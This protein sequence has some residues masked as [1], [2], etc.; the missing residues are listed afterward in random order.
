M[1][2]IVVHNAMGDK[3][4]AGLSTEISSLID[5]DIFGVSVM[6]PDP[7]IFYRF[8]ALP[9]RHRINQRSHTMH[10]TKTG[11]F[12]M[13]LAKRGQS[14]EMFSYLAGFLCHYAMDSTSHPFIYGA[15][16][17]RA[18]MHTAVEHRLDVLELERHGKQRRDLMKLFTKY[19]DLPEV[20]ET[21]KAVY[22]WDD[23][24]YAIG[25][26]HM[27]LYHWIVK[28]QHGVLNRIIGWLPGKLSTISYQ[29]RKADQIDL[30]SFDG[31]MAEAVD[32]GIRLVTATYDFR[33]GI[34][35][36]DELSE[37]IGNR[38]YAGGESEG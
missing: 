33:K 34:I 17:D 21:L 11:Q 37:V 31:L 3:V 1:P 35:S 5:R 6:G 12:L 26:R 30:S 23:D 27:K 20:R 7:Y 2:D 10:H 18:D 4:L 9:F 24:C 32:M 15:A 14:P 13:E 8:F 25:Y 36:E 38:S 16:D 28:D 19:R 22:G 29:T